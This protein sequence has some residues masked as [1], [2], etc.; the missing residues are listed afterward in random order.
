MTSA[1]SWR[2][3]QKRIFAADKKLRL[4]HQS[5]IEHLTYRGSRYGT[6]LSIMGCKELELLFVCS[7]SFVDHFLET[8]LALGV[9]LQLQKIS[10]ELRPSRVSTLSN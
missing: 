9:K 3:V 8:D 1:D 7:A 5:L 2:D 6:W 10:A 4:E